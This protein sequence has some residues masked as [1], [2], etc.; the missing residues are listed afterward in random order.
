MI[1]L[2]S[3]MLGQDC[4]FEMACRV[5]RDLTDAGYKTM[6]FDTSGSIPAGYESPNVVPDDVFFPILEKVIKGLQ[7]EG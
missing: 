3:E 7:V 4:S 1:Y 6:A 2:T 5:A